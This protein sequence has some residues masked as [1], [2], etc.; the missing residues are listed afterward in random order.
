MHITEGIITGSTAVL[1]SAAGVG[2]VSL[3]VY[4]MK[5]FV[6]E[7]PLNKPLLGMGAAI[8]F[9]ISLIPIPAFTGT[10]SHPCG[11]PLVAILLGPSIGFAL[12]GASLLL[13]AA[14]FAHGGFGTW[15]ANVVALGFFGCFF[16][17][18]VFRLMR[19]L[20]LPLWTA[21]MAG[22]LI[23]NIAVYASSGLILGLAFTGAPDPQYSLA[24]YL[25]A[26]YSA[27]LPTQV[28]IALG[29]MILTGLALHYANK[30]RP[31]VLEE[32]GVTGGRRKSVPGS[33]I[34]AVVFAVLLAGSFARV[35]YGWSEERNA[36]GQLNAGV[37]AQKADAAL[38]T[39]MDESVNE[40]FAEEAGLK[41]QEPYIDTE[42]WGDIWNLLLLG[43][44]GVCGFVVGR[45]WHLLWGGRK[46]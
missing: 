32:L 39:G 11:T 34:G 14:F 24:G 26:I 29:E 20:G 40:Q 18:G 8:I 28:P 2:L 44:G 9:F 5:R 3:G 46:R 19:L 15:G 27:Y 30:Q 16:G 25:V 21:G 41:V 22:G 38:F 31:E 42:S 4:R 23:G 13:Q 37:V 6:R 12:A 43:A 10:C 7:A 35:E 17:W 1:Y 33:A 36:A 45:T